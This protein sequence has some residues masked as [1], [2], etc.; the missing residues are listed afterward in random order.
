MVQGSLGKKQDPITKITRAK[1]A[2]GVAK[3]VEHLPPKC[4]AL[5]PH[6]VLPK[7]KKRRRRKRKGEQK[8]MGK[9]E[10]GT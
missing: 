6:P 5:S 2:G 7:K 4:K 10:L 3:V 1:K 9:G 8:T